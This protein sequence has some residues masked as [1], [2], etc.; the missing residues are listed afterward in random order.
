MAIAELSLSQTSTSSS[1]SGMSARVRALRENLLDTMP[2][3]CVERARYF[4]EAYRK[5]ENDPMV[6]R[7]A[8]SLAH[9]LANMTI[10]IQPGEVLVGNQASAPRAAPIFPEFSVDWIAPEIDEFIHRP[11]DRFT[12]NP[13][14]K[15]ELLEEIIPY[16]E[17]RTL[18]D[19]AR[20]G[21][22]EDVWQA[23]DMGLISG[24]GNITSGDGHI[25]MDIPRVLAEGLEGFIQRAEV[26]L[27]AL[28]STTHMEDLK[29]V[30]FL[31]GA[32]IACRAAIRFAERYT[33][34]AERQAAACSDPQRKEELRRIAAIC[35]R[36][37]GK[38][39][40]SFQ[41][42]V[43]SAWFVHLISQIESNGHSFSM[44]R[45]DQYAYPFYQADMQAGLITR[46]FALDLVEQL[47]LKLFSVIKIRPWSHTRFGI[48]Y[49]TYQNVTVGGQT[50]DGKDATNELSY[51]VLE[52][53]RETRLTQPNVSARYHSGTPDRFLF[54]CA[55]TIRLGFGM[56]AMKND[57]MIIP[58]LLEKGVVSEDAYNYAIVGC[59]EAAVPGKWGY[60]NTGMAF[61]NLLKVLELAYNNG[62]DTVTGVTLHPGKGRLEDFTTFEELYAAFYDQMKY[63]TRAHVVF[64]TIADLSLEELSPD[65]FCSALVDDCLERG[66]TIKEGGSVYDVVSGL[67]SGLANVAN[68]LMALKTRVFDEK[69]LSAE[70][71]HEALSTNFEGIPGEK[72][73]QQLLSVPKYGNDIAEV[74]DLA[75]RVLSDYLEIV[76]PYR[77]TRAGRGPI[78]CNYAGS[79][80]NISANVPMGQPVC[81]T[82]DGRRAGEPI[83]EGV[84]NFH[85]T[86]TRGP[87]AVMRSVTKLPTIKMLAQLLNLR[88]SPATLATDAGL[89][90]LVTLLRGF[91][92][93]KGWHVQF[94]V[95]D[96]KTLKLAQANPE[97]YKDLVVRVAGY[98]ALFVSL[99]KATQDDIIMRTELE[100]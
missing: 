56:P 60:R 71:V 19:R 2:S 5:H 99:D 84:S 50:P 87:T 12:V 25:I 93:L 33:E 61:L 31:Q 1:S 63:Y 41:E 66:K 98:S 35:R 59:V 14:V 8:K 96:S 18:Y 53:I 51:L 36:V 83:A 46:E 16:W 6:L 15:R 94:N 81:A 40:H 34:E 91:Q 97:E 39:A 11:A 28:Q 67:Q 55:R 58:A 73:R 78:G 88:L 72:I 42:A 77:T 85:G 70:E 10:Y 13:E 68:A 90:R 45:F 30:A 20:A 54:E 32:V 75:V 22:P 74:D 4:T 65:A 38:P 43:Q 49:P 92:A 23:Q 24:R 26:R 29:A 64:D 37:P 86:D 95:V 44:G 69:T 48:G 80:S 62:Q 21:M 27:E 3:V 89:W 82:P 47:W 52:T 100:L 76:K 9:V 17:G 7:R 79:T 57:E